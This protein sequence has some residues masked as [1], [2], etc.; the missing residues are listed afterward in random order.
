MKEN[1]NVFL[2]GLRTLL[3]PQRNYMETTQLGKKQGMPTL[4]HFVVLLTVLVSVNGWSKESYAATTNASFAFFQ[5]TAPV[6][7]GASNITPTS[8]IIKWNAVTDVTTPTYIVELYTDATFT[9]AVGTVGNTTATN[10][11]V[12]GLTDATT[13]YF[14]VKSSAAGSY[15]TGSFTTGKGYSP[16]EVTGF[17]NDVIASGTGPN[18]GATTNA[19]FTSTDAPVDTSDYAYPSRDYKPLPT[20]AAITVGLPVN[21]NLTPSIAAT[22]GI[23]YHMADYGPAVGFSNNSLRVTTTPGTLSLVT[24][25]KLSSLYLAVASG[26]GDT[27]MTTEVLFSDGTIQTV[28]G[29]PVT[30]WDGTATTAA[31]AIITNIGRVSR[32]SGTVETLNCKLFQVTVNI[33]LANQNKLVSGVRVT[34]T[35]AATIV[36]VFAVSGKLLGSCPIISGNTAVAASLTSGTFGWTLSQLGDG[37]TTGTYTL[38]VATDAAFANPVAGSPFT[39]AAT[40]TSRLVTGLTLDTPYFYRIKVSNGTCD[41]NILTGTFTPA[42]C[43]PTRTST[44]TAVATVN[45]ISNFATTGGYTNITNATTNATAGSVYNNYASQVVSKAAGTTFNFNGTKGSALATGYVDIFVDWNN[46]TDFDDAGEIVA[47]VNQAATAFSGTITIPAGTALGNYRMRVRSRV[48]GNNATASGCGSY[49][50]GETED[51]TLSVVAAPANCVAPAPATIA[52]TNTAGTATGTITAPATAPSGYLVIRGTTPTLT[53]QPVTGTTYFAGGTVGG[54]VVLSNSA[55]ITNI[56]DFLP[57]NAH[58]YYFVYT[59]NDATSCFGPIYST[60]AVGDVVTCAGPVRVAA[61]SNIKSTTATINWSSIAGPGGAAATYNLEVSTVATFATTIGTYPNLTATSYNLTG[62]TSGTVYYFRVSGTA[63]TCGD[64]TF[65]NGSFTAQNSFTPISINPADFNADV[66]ANGRGLATTTTNNDIDGGGYVY[67]SIDYK[68][69]PTASYTYG[70][71]ENR[72]LINTTANPQVPYLL[73]DYTGNNALRL[74]A[75]Q[76]GT[77]RFTT[78][79]KLSEVYISATGGNGNSTVTATIN[80]QDGSAPVVVTGIT[81]PDWFNGSGTVIA[82]DVGR[83]DK[84][85]TAQN[86]E[87]GA[88]KIYQ[89][90]IPIT[91]VN[92]QGK[93]ITGV[94][95]TKTTTANVA[96]I[97]GVSG[98][99]VGACP[100]MGTVTSAVVPGSNSSATLTYDIVSAGEAGAAITYTVEV[101]TN[102]AMTTPIAGSPFAATSAKTF[103]VPGLTPY[104]VYYARVKANNGICD[105]DYGL[106]QIVVTGCKPAPSSVDV[107]GIT[108]VTIGTINNSTGTEPNNYGDYSAMAASTWANAVVPFS[109]TF[110]TGTGTFGY[111]YNTKIWVDWNNDLDFDDAGEEVYSGLSAA[112]GTAVLTGTFTVPAGTALGKYRL[113]IGGADSSIPTPCYTGTY[114]T[115]EDYSLNI[116]PAPAPCVAP[117]APTVVASATGSTVTGTVTAPATGTATGYLVIRSTTA[118]LTA[119][120]VNVTNYAVG[121]TVGGGTVVAVG[122][123]VPAFTQ[124]LTAN[125]K[126]YYFAYAYNDGGATCLGPIYSAAATANVTTLDCTIKPV[127]AFATYITNSTATLNWSA[128]TGPGDVVANYTV[129]VYKDAALTALFNSYTT[130]STNFDVT[131]LTNGSTYYFR[132]KGSVTGCTDATWSTA[133]SFTAQNSFVAFNLTGFNADV[134]ANG[135][136]LAST[137]TTAAVDAV[138]NA[139]LSLD[140]KAT[141]TAAAAT[142]GLPVNRTLQGNQLNLKLMLEDYGRNNSLRLAAQ[143]A[144][145][146]LALSKPTKATDL[147]IAVTSGSGAAVISA[148]VQFTDGTT[149][150]STSFTLINWDSATTADAPGIAINIGRVNR[151]DANGNPEAGNFKVFQLTLPILAANQAKTIQ[152]VKFVKTSTGA[153]EPVAHIF[154]I[155]GKVID[156]CPVLEETTAVAA[157]TSAE[158]SWTQTSPGTGTGLTYSVEVYTDEAMTLPVTG[159]PFAAG[160]ASPYTVT[161][162]AT[163]TTYYYQVKATNSICTSAAITGTFTTVCPVIA[164][165]VAAAQT[166]CANSTIANLAVTGTGTTP[167]FNWYAT[168][169]STTVLAATTV[170]TEGTYYVAQTVSGCES[171]RLAVVV[172]VTALPTAPV[173]DA[174]KTVCSDAIVA[175]LTATGENGSTIKWYTTAN[176]TEPALSSDFTLVAGTYYVTQT[177]GACTS[178]AAQ[179]V[180]TVNP[181]PAAPVADALQTYCAGSTVADLDATFATDATFA[182]YTPG[183]GTPL[184]TTEVLV[185]G[186]YYVTQTVNGCTSLPTTITV[187]I[188]TVT[189]PVVANQSFCDAATLAEVKNEV[190]DGATVNWFNP[191]GDAITDTTSLTSGTY[192]VSQTVGDCT[193]VVTTFTVTVTPTP[194]APTGAA[195]QDFVAGDTLADFDVTL[196]TGATIQWFTKAT[197]GTFTAVPATTV[198]EDGVTYYAT[199]SSGTCESPTFAVTAHKVLGTDE[200]TFKHL[201][202]YPNPVADVL[203]IANTSAITK[204]VVINLIG[205]TVF[206]RKANDTT[207]QINT[208]A[209]QAGPYILQVYSANNFATVKFIK[210]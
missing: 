174:T 46:D 77:L 133:S 113:R 44:S 117:S 196:V 13:Y 15:G 104:V 161:G 59:Y 162:L 66:I 129:E 60:A 115:F 135:T 35:G 148:E 102:A 61:T 169:T 147:Y 153:T 158:I 193:S 62:L 206:E 30:N 27:T 49:T 16:L 80:F 118:T 112:A 41:S 74:T 89:V 39:G 200:F 101:F 191:A 95:F 91:D 205:Q 173:V 97:F 170:V 116:V 146:V 96:N 181:K 160:T 28:T 72:T 179:T 143:N 152:G 4:S 78:P 33:D 90:R 103:T 175:D 140:Y 69:N 19:A 63:G 208:Q 6:I 163:S 98:R 142:Y 56:S 130:T 172:T 108:N 29:L 154:A 68:N 150:A 70:L 127:A 159:S 53:A 131:G 38:D 190:I 168:Q 22:P 107:N 17:T 177:V 123:T 188:T 201:T 54:G 171:T 5:T 106:T 34:R 144:E 26:G 182:W 167:V 51:Y 166:V 76:S 37:A 84:K 52:V 36:N 137:S 67:S 125:T 138:S 55:A 197:D 99:V 176:L 45:I 134:I 128:I 71:P 79:I 25:L 141:A 23:V 81:M 110:N 180:V 92:Q 209:L 156:A 2:S 32:N 202:V 184:A 120:P 64:A 75:L 58:Y 93:F 24:P 11:P 207:V 42:Y 83:V 199:Q 121:A 82:G 204:V 111:D 87:A 31:P 136:G 9:T 40:V 1:Y 65:S 57:A 50:Y 43:A 203:T 132:V 114:A 21:R 210:K 86:V 73:S 7:V 157:S 126:Y 186:S 187:E 12:T 105:S 183:T 192:S 122:T 149:Q 155:S 88:S 198:V 14:R 48:S 94:T 185:A 178:L 109:I 10:Y 20:S 145:G 85:T 194:A 189:P 195:T 18:N 8:A 119:Q 139:Y 100:S 164:T 124:V 165:P 151:A 3:R 47:S